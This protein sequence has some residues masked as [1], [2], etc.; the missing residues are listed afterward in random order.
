M[1]GVPQQQ[2][3]MLCAGCCWGME[4]RLAQV[5][6]RRILFVSVLCYCACR[7]EVVRLEQ[8]MSLLQALVE[9]VAANKV[10][11]WQEQADMAKELSAL[12]GE[13]LNLLR[14]LHEL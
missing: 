13:K 10:L 5:A 9:Y 14:H 3:T 8:A 12:L 11:H 1:C 6:T 2:P 7:E 4:V